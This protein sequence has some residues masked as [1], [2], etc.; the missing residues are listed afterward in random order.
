ML[1]QLRNKNFYL[2]LFL[3]IALFTASLFLAYNVRFAFGIPPAEFAGLVAILPLVLAVKT[4][5][6]FIAG[7]YRGMWRYTSLPDLVQL[8]KG[9]LVASLLIMAFLTFANHFTGFPRS[10]F[11]ADAIFTLF[12]CAGL[13]AAIRL[14]SGQPWFGNSHPAHEV[15]APAE[16]KR[17]RLLILGAGDAAGTILREIQGNSRSQFE[18]IACLDDDPEKHGRTLLGVPVRGPIDKVEEIAAS[19]RADE[20]LIAMPSAT[21]SRMREI[22]TMCEKAGLPY[23]TLPSLSSLVDGRVTIND[24]RS[25]NFEDLLGRPP[26]KWQADEIG[27]YLTGRTVAVTGAGGSIGSELCRQ[28]VQFK[29][30]ALILIDA[31]E[32][33]LYAIEMELRKM[34]LVETIVPVMGRVQDRPLISRVLQAHRPQVLFHAAA[35][36]H[37]PMVEVNPW[38][39][40]FNNIL[41]GQVVMDVAEEVGVE[42]FVQVSTDKAVRPTNV[43]GASKRMVEILLQSRKSRVTRFMAVRFGNVVGSSGSVIPLFQKQIRAGG[44]VTVTHP[45]MTRYFMTIPEACQ[46]ILQAGAMGEGGEIFILEMGTPVRI[47]DMARDLIRLSGKTPG[48]DIDIVF[49]GLRPGEKLYEELITHGEGIVPTPHKKIMVLR[50]N[51]S[52]STQA[53]LERRSLAGLSDLVRAAQSYD[54]ELIRSVLKRHI[55]EYAPSETGSVLE[56]GT[57]VSGSVFDRAAKE[58]GR[59]SRRVAAEAERRESDGMAAGIP[60]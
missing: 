6:F 38:E 14:L 50:R 15:E 11:A 1:N 23:K 27:R 7:S 53:Q 25:V 16:S 19:L 42:K 13:R 44:P 5:C 37:V 58:R 39:A 32:F 43:M 24:L 26:V 35:Y 59:E 3:D 57:P 34:E 54:A 4:L 40:V 31:N 21:G 48:R 52:S 36:K 33:N 20:I 47:A 28:I 46:L 49:T 51:E 17:C 29:P 56:G 9:A 30:R 60:A 12:F 55:P 41:G 45:E 8:A 10:V 22:V 18:A 2:L